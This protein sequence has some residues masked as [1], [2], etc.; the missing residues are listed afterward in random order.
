MGTV[1]AKRAPTGATH[2]ARGSSGTAPHA[3][4][5]PGRPVGRFAVRTK[6]TLSGAS[7]GPGGAS[8]TSRRGF[9]ARAVPLEPTVLGAGDPD[10]CFRAEPAA[11]IAQVC[12]AQWS[13]AGAGPQ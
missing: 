8:L 3:H 12:G 7:A 11:W 2:K 6:G 9:P 1:S 13:V 10:A 5:T 4:G